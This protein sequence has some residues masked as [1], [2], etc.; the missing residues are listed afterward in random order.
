MR[1]LVALLSCVLVGCAARKP[2]SPQASAVMVGEL[3]VD[4]PT[5]E[6]GLLEFSLRLPADAPPVQAVSWEL[7]LEGIRFGAGLDSAQQRE[8]ATVTVQTPLVSR[9]LSWRE[10]DA[11]LEV[12]LRGEVDVGI[13]GER[14]PFRERREVPVHGRPML[15]IPVE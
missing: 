5:R 13:P 15:N 8:G 1:R 9:H 4:F 3:K 6:R 2:G 10:G 14:L 11:M 7:F 12:G